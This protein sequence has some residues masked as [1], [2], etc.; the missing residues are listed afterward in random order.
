MQEFKIK[1]TISLP[2]K[3]I[4]KL[5]TKSMGITRPQEIAY[6]CVKKYL[7]KHAQQQLSNAANCLYNREQPCSGKIKFC[8]TPR[9][10]HTLKTMRYT[11]NI[12]VSFLTYKAINLYLESIVKYY[13]GLYKVNNMRNLKRYNKLQKHY[14]DFFKHIHRKVSFSGNSIFGLRLIIPIPK[15]FHRETTENTP[16]YWK[17]FRI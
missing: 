15:M 1:T 10:H 14:K 9:E 5:Q 12:S 3:T 4:I 11:Q 7:R 13:Q 6:A 17:K 2:E 8:L 16:F